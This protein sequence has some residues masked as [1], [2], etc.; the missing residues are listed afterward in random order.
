MIIGALDMSLSGAGITILSEE[1]SILHQEKLSSEKMNTKAH[2]GETRLRIISP[3]NTI[4]SEEYIPSSNLL[5]MRRVAFFKNRI[6]SLFKDHKVSHVVIEGYSFNSKGRSVIS[7]GELGGVIR[8]A[9]YEA[10]IPY[11]QCP[12]FNAKAFMTGLAWA[13]KEQMQEGIKEN[14]DL[15]IEDDNIA[16]SYAMAQMMRVFKEKMIEVCSEGG[17]D[18][19]KEYRADEIRKKYQDKIEVFKRVLAIGQVSNED[20]ADAM[21]ALGDKD[22]KEISSI[23][24]IEEADLIAQE[25]KMNL[26]KL[27]EKYKMKKPKG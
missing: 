10:N 2:K 14:Y 26:K 4:T 7:L 15:W 19:L 23:L 25:K 27:N 20:W 6:I 3:D 8:F 21:G 11:I 16:D 24:N 1:G 17:V 18:K 13:K 22:H 5:D 12:P 9:L